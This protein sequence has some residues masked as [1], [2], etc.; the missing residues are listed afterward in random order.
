MLRLD[1]SGLIRLNYFFK[2]FVYEKTGRFSGS[3]NVF[4][5]FN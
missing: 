1:V 2:E 4:N 5:W 3:I